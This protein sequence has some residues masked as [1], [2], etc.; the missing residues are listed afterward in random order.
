MKS[1]SNVRRRKVSNETPRVLEGSY[2]RR[3]HVEGNK[4]YEDERLNINS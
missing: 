3:L 4:G 1:M 2:S